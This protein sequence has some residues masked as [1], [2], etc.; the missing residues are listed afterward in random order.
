MPFKECLTFLCARKGQSQLIWINIGT[1]TKQ[2]KAKSLLA[3]LGFRIDCNAE[4]VVESVAQSNFC[5][6]EL[7]IQ[8]ERPLD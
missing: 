3:L 6:D 7:M 2:V 8:E 5:F 4:R 1:T